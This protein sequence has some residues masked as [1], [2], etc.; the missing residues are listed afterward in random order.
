MAPPGTLES[1]NINHLCP[2]DPAKAKA[3]L[4]ETGYGPSKPL[5]LDL[6]TNTEKSVFGD[7]AGVI[8]E[9][10][11][12]IGTAVSQLA[13]DQQRRWRELKDL[14]LEEG[15]VLVDGPGLTESEASWLED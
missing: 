3:L 5:A 9:Q 4:T 10:L 1:V 8:K 6:M 2:Y 11:A 15:I 12:R 14:L 13:S 7:I